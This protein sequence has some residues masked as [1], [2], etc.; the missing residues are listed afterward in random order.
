MKTNDLADSSSIAILDSGVG[1]LSVLAALQKQLPHENFLYVA[2][3]AH[4]PYG[5]K[6]PDCIEESIERI[7]DTIVDFP[8]KLAV[9]A[10]HTSSALALP[11][12]EIS[13]P[14]P[15]V[16]IIEPTLEL[17]EKNHEDKTILLLATD[18]TIASGVYTYP[19][20]KRSPSS[21]FYSLNCSLLV[22]A[23]ENHPT[24]ALIE[25]VLEE[26]FTDIPLEEID[27]VVLACTHFPLILSQLRQFLPKHIE[28]LDP[29]AACAKAVGELLAFRS[30]LD[31]E[32]QSPPLFCTTDH[33]DRFLEI[34]SKYLKIPPTRIY[35]IN[36]DAKQ[37]EIIL[38]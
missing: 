21:R 33:P 36:T 23:I 35:R 32:N 27:T 1:G 11:S 24:T 25:K 17:L 9:F 34:A 12:L 31:E 26:I 20:K 7:L 3:T 6:S 22:S 10:C 29:S 13:S 5:T 19:M 38:Q 16:G 14:I 18:A 4:S 30:E 8:I 28:I 15:L 37:D 2:D